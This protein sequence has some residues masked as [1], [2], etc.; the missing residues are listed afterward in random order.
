MLEKCHERPLDLRAAS[1]YAMVDVVIN[2]N[3]VSPKNYAESL[4]Q[5]YQRLG[6]D[7]ATAG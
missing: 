3:G 6:G 4:T 1:P 7:S 5:A 2:S